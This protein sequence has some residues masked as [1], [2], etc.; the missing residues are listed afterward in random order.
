[1]KENSYS[2]M[3]TEQLKKTISATTAIT[4][5][6]GAMLLVLIGM[7]VYNKIQENNG[8]LSI[9]VPLCLSPIFF[10]NLINIGNMKKE[11][12]NREVNN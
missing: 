11:L 8:S 1:M 9:A 3:T 4:G 10:L 6:L 7:I 12:K 2:K 5:M